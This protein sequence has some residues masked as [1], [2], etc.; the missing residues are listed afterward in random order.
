MMS[1]FGDGG[2]ITVKDL[3]EMDQ[4]LKKTMVDRLNYSEIYFTYKGKHFMVNK[5]GLYSLD[6]N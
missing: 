2:I 6:E 5:D 3:Y 1:D 4:L